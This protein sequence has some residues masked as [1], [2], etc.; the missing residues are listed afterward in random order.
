MQNRLRILSL[1]RPRQAGI[2]A[3][4]PRVYI[5]RKFIRVKV[6][7]SL[8]S[9]VVRKRFGTVHRRICARIS[10]ALSWARLLLR[11]W[12]IIII[13]T[14][15]RMITALSVARGKEM[16][17]ER[18]RREFLQKDATGRREATARCTCR[19]CLTCEITMIDTVKLKVTTARRK[20]F[21]PH[22]SVVA[23]RC[24]VDW[25]R[26]FIRAG[27]GFSPVLL[28]LPAFS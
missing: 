6:L 19:Y 28:L 11:W 26:S 10:A 21:V 3:P 22:C 25:L 27:A 24:V 18:Q 1:C 13:I 16:K 7:M 8:L 9:S 14:I 15:I 5:E 12:L 23:G 20:T 4:A 2:S 17:S